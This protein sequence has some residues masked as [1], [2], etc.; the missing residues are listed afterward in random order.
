MAGLVRRADV[1]AVDT[2]DIG[3]DRSGKA[4]WLSAAG[5]AG[6]VLMAAG[7]FGA[8]A[9]LWIDPNESPFA[10]HFAD[11]TVGYGIGLGVWLVGAVVLATAWWRLG[12]L[13]RAGGVTGRWMTRTALIWAVPFLFSAPMGSRDIYAY[14]CQGL[15][16]AHG[17]NPYAMGPAALPS[18]WLPAM[19][20]YWQH[21]PAPYGP[22][23]LLVSGGAAALAGGHLVL[24]L[25]W[26][27]LAA[28][29][30]VAL[31][32]VFVPR[33]A[34]TCGV[35][36]AEAAWLGAA[37]P[38]VAVDLLS[39]AHHGVW[40]IGLLFACLDL[41]ARRPA[42]PAGIVLGLAGAV[43]ATA[44]IAV[45]FA[46]VLVAPALVGRNRL[47]RGGVVVALPTVAAFLT[48]T[49]VSRLGFGWTKATPGPHSLIHWL[50]P[51]TGVGMVTGELLHLAGYPHA[52]ATTVPIVRVVAWYVVLPA[53][54][55]AL[56]WRVHR[57]TDRR[58]VVEQTGYALAAAVLLSP[59]VYPWY[60]LAPISVLAVA[61]T[62]PRVRTVLAVVTLFGLFVILPDG[63]NLAYPTKWFGAVAD[64]FVLAFLATRAVR[65]RALPVIRR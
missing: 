51:P 19:S 42:W 34:R 22:L 33:L 20:A 65:T 62:E 37:S 4:T 56:W 64:V 41:A 31:I 60:Y 17:L 39:A 40:M 8:G 5:T 7:S 18:P 53:V 14:A 43:K 55:I 48:M 46:A 28:M 23:A 35:P 30:G 24:A 29:A 12:R 6:S 59:L 44:L 27:R 63:F 50:S 15:L 52:I 25:G 58:R 49:G 3:R 9:T 2:D 13:V 36:P 47:V 32:A 45:P 26:L 38:L 11:V 10:E 54:L 57:S 61:V 16:Y 1:S 21:T